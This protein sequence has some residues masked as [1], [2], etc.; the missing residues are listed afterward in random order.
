MGDIFTCA[1]FMN[2]SEYCIGNIKD[3]NIKKEKY[4][5]VPINQIKECA[6]YWA[7]QLCLG[8]C[9]AQKIYMGRRCDSA[10]T[11]TFYIKLYFYI[12]QNAPGYLINS[13]EEKEGV[14]NCGN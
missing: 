8:G 1:H 4:I 12:M 6:D 14:I 13:T 11:W 5:P 7:K 10:Q 3:E 2:N 9:L